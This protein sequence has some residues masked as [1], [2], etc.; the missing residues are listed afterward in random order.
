MNILHLEDSDNDAE[1]IREALC[2]EVTDCHVTRVETRKAFL[3]AM[4]Q[5]DWDIILADYCLPSFDGISALKLAVEKCPDLP[6]IFVTGFLGEQL[7]VET[8]KNGATDYILKH[9][10]DRLPQAVIRAKRESESAKAKKEAEQKLRDS[11]REKELLLQELHHR[12]NNNLQV[13]SSLI[14]LQAG[15]IH[16][17]RLAAALQECQQRVQSMAIIHAMLYTSSSLKDIDFAEYARVLT[18]EVSNSYGMDPTRIRLAFELEPIRLEIDRAIPC[19]LILN[20]LLS[21]AFKYAFP[22]T[23]CGEI[24]VSLQQRE[25]CIRLA[26][27]DTG[28]GLSER[29]LSERKSLGLEIVN[30]LSEQLGGSMEITSNQGAQFVLTMI[31]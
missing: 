22:D 28:I 2:D 13:I 3:E 21:N 30:I 12:V 11:L 25:H 29:S 14:E 20:E 31:S 8:L 15:A 19:G 24:R 18:T 9:R 23:C 1:L 7:A 5:S 16:D 26:V 4:D 27:E 17:P 10:L 6:F